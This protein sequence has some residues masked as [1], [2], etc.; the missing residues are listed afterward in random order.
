MD[1]FAFRYRQFRVAPSLSGMNHLKGTGDE[2]F[3]KN[4]LGFMV[5]QLVHSFGS[6]LSS[7][8]VASPKESFH[9]IFH[10]TSTFDNSFNVTERMLKRWIS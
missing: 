3:V 9:G 7:A 4:E 10:R 8:A 6:R 5:S 1:T 2:I